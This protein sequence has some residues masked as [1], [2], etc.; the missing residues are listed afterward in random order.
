[1]IVINNKQRLIVTGF[2]VLISAL[3]ISASWWNTQNNTKVNNIKFLTPSPIVIDG[4][5]SSG[6]WD[7]AENVTQWYMDA[8]PANYDGY[9]YMYIEEDADNVYI[10]LDLVSDQTNDETG[11]WL[12]LW[13]NTNNTVLTNLDQN[14]GFKNWYDKLDNGFESLII[15]VENNQIMPFFSAGHAVEDFEIKSLN[16]LDILNGTFQGTL[17]DLKWYEGNRA[18]VTSQNYGAEHVYRIDFNLDLKEYFDIFPELYVPTTISA[19]LTCSLLNNESITEQ[20]LSIRDSS[21]NLL[22]SSPDHT[23]T[24]SSGTNIFTDSISGLAGNFSTND[25]VH[26]TL[27]GKSNAAFETYIEEITF[28]PLRQQNPWLAEGWLEYPYSSIETYEIDWSFAGSDNNATAHRMF[29]IKI[30]KTE[31]EEYSQ[32]ADL[33]LMIGGYGTLLSFPNTNHWILAN[34]TDSGTPIYYTPYYHYYDMPMKGWTQPNTPVLAP[35]NPNP[36]VTGDITLNWDTDPNVHNWTVLRYDSEITDL[37]INDVII[38]STGIVSN[39]YTDTDLTSGT[40]WYAIAA[41]DTLGYAYLSNN[42]SVV[43]EI[44]AE[45]TTSSSSSSTS[46]T[47]SSQSTMSST[48]DISSDSKTD[49]DSSPGFLHKFSIFTLIF[50]VVIYRSRKKL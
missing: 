10:A 31:L 40:Y 8:D 42:E 36:S 38:V 33:G 9:N 28:S 23:K 5:I 19:A 29:E 43:V 2:A 47:S 48:S 41:V 18:Q 20:Y 27:M 49:E 26:F 24:I 11:E 44:P 14:V 22:L 25:V 12:G 21:G 30:P 6:E 45:S 16:H 37:N 39:T 35:I 50:V 4:I 7:D 13:L 1:M 17:E 46:E 15:D 34:G 3:L 32:D